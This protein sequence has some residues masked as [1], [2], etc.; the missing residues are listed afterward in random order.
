MKLYG[1]TLALIAAAISLSNT[2]LA[3]K[4]FSFEGDWIAG[5]LA[6]EFRK[7]ITIKNCHKQKCAFTFQQGTGQDYCSFEG[8]FQKQGTQT[9]Q[10]LISVPHQTNSYCIINISQKNQNTLRVRGQNCSAL[11]PKGAMIDDDYTNQNA[12]SYYETGYDCYDERNTYAEVAICRN[13]LLSLGHKEAQNLQQ[14]AQFNQTL[15]KD[16]EKGRNF[17]QSDTKCLLPKYTNFIEALSKKISQTDFNLHTYYQQTQNGYGSPFESFLTYQ[18]LQNGMPPQAQKQY[19]A[20]IGKRVDRSQSNYIFITYLPQGEDKVERGIF[21]L[22]N[23]DMWIGYLIPGE[24]G[25]EEF[26]LYAPQGKNIMDTP[27]AIQEWE[28]KYQNINCKYKLGCLEDLYP[29]IN[30]T[31]TL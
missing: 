22:K 24:N 26:F 20:Q 6:G 3:E 8:V 27:K 18:K 15:I 21:Y 7:D 19:E 5:R 30:F 16:W 10:I 11:C 23:N 31:P 25:N 9:G 13:R 2:A 17:C 14:K 28:K 1:K 12:E 4:P 29:K